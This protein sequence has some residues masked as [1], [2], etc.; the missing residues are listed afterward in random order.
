[1]DK[2]RSIWSDNCLSKC[3]D[4]NPEGWLDE[5]PDSLLDENPSEKLFGSLKRW[6]EV[7]KDGLGLEG[8]QGWRQECIYV[9]KE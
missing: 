5:N 6:D 2:F 7:L 3:L 9:E 4:E 1:M 8:S